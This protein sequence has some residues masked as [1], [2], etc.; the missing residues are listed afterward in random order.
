MEC[1]SK[2]VLMA[3]YQL[4]KT[5]PQTSVAMQTLL[6]VIRLQF[7]KQQSHHGVGMVQ[8][9]ISLELELNLGIK[10]TKVFPFVVSN[11]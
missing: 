6:F 1:S 4:G 9:E 11:K 10:A 7:V 2:R 5:L 8:V 3:S